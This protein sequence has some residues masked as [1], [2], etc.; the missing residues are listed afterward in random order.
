M[1]SETYLYEIRTDCP[2]EV[3]KS[4]ET[5]NNFGFKDNEL[6]ATKEKKLLNQIMAYHSSFSYEMLRNA[7]D[8]ETCS[9]LKD[10]DLQL[11]MKFSDVKLKRKSRGYTFKVDI[12]FHADEWKDYDLYL[13]PM[14][15]LESKSKSKSEISPKIKEFKNGKVYFEYHGKIAIEELYQI[16]FQF[17]SSSYQKLITSL[18]LINEQHLQN[19]FLE[20]DVAPEKCPIIFKDHKKVEILEWFDKRV[21]TNNE[22]M[23]AIKKIVNCTAYPFPFIIFGPPGTG[24]TSTLVECVAQILQHKPDSRILITAQSNSACDEIGARLLKAVDRK[25]IYRIYSISQL[26]NQESTE[27][28]K[29]LLKISNLRNNRDHAV[30]SGQI[31]YFNVVIATLMKSNL[32]TKFKK[33]Y[34]YYDYIFVDECASATELECLVPIMGKFKRTSATVLSKLI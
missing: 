29:E 23:M 2:H 26:K 15:F 22:Q 1:N 12:K 27:M 21:E 20:F 13:I 14:K 25:K 5:L 16:R 9:I 6:L 10:S 24:K 18:L 17:Y 32:L 34:N 31:E 7:L 30:T 19:Y 4:I 3:N 33:R 8:I 28:R 11:E